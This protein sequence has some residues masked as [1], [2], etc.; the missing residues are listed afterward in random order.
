MPSKSIGFYI[1]DDDWEIYC[2]NSEVLNQVAR[3]AMFKELDRIK[4]AVIN[5]GVPVLVED[6][7]EE[8]VHKKMAQKARNEAQDAL[9]KVNERHKKGTKR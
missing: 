4:K 6:L 1:N 8:A 7:Q 9:Y 3:D 2:E 5:A